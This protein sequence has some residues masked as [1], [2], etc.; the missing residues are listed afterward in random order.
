MSVILYILTSIEKRLM[1]LWSHTSADTLYVRETLARS[2]LLWPNF[3][4]LWTGTVFCGHADK[5]WPFSVDTPTNIASSWD[6]KLWACF[7]AA[8]VWNH[9]ARCILHTPIPT[10]PANLPPPISCNS[11]FAAKSTTQSYTKSS[12]DIGCFKFL[13]RVLVSEGWIWGQQPAFPHND[14]ETHWSFNWQR[15]WSTA[16]PLVHA[17]EESWNSPELRRVSFIQ[18]FIHSGYIEHFIQH[19][20]IL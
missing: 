1:S 14:S 13:L 2:C 15:W 8:L 4:N 10:S 5:R 18:H 3:V 9:F 20:S 12:A 6:H 11:T 19:F 16:W 17:S 7:A